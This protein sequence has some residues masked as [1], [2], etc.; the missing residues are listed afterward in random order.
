MTTRARLRH[1]LLVAIM[2]L[3]LSPGRAAG[4]PQ[5]AAAADP[6]LTVSISGDQ[7]I[8]SWE[9]REWTISIRNPNDFR[10]HDV[11]VD[12][13]DF[14]LPIDYSYIGGPTGACRIRDDWGMSSKTRATCEL[15]SLLPRE[16]VY[17][18]LNGSTTLVV[19]SGNDFLRVRASANYPVNTTADGSAN[20][21]TAWCKTLV[22]PACQRQ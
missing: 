7:I 4:A 9:T 1:G 8:Y 20:K 22:V 17:I 12:I 10:A 5:P 14:H 6:P 3:G 11:F 15:G 18:G 13:H 16:I 2:A 21:R 19:G